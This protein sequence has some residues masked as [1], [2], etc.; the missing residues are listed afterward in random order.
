MTEP[1]NRADEPGKDI[2]VAAQDRV[3][4]LAPYVQ[5]VLSALGYGRVLVTDESLVGDFFESY[6]L[7][8]SNDPQSAEQKVEDDLRLAM[9]AEEL[10]VTVTYEDY[11]ADVAERLQGGQ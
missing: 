4:R 10:G 2:R 1:T 7:R 5:R 3:K 8:E 6:L 9:A 11:V